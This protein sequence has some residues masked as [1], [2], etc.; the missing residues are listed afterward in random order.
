MVLGVSILKHFR[1]HL[2]GHF[3]LLKCTTLHVQV[4]PATQ[5]QTSANQKGP[6]IEVM[7][8]VSHFECNFCS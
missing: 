6:F 8:H 4:P 3:H 5:N 1:V 7:V 2:K